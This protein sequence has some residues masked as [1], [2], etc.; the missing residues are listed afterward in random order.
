MGTQGAE[1]VGLGALDHHLA[2]HRGDPRRSPGAVRLARTGRLVFPNN[3]GHPISGV[4]L[5]EQPLQPGAGSGGVSCRFHDLRH[6]SVAL[7]IAAGPIQ[8]DPDRMGHSSIN[9]T[10][11]RYGHLFPELDEAIATSFETEIAALGLPAR[12]KSF[13]AH[14]RARAWHWSSFPPP[15]PTESAVYQVYSSTG[16]PV[17][18]FVTRHE[19]QK[20]RSRR[21][22]GERA[23]GAK[24][25]PISRHGGRRSY[26]SALPPRP[27]NYV[28]G[29]RG[30]TSRCQRVAR[31]P[32]KSAARRDRTPLPFV[33]RPEGVPGEIQKTARGVSIPAADETGRSR[34]FTASW[35]RSGPISGPGD[36]SRSH[37]CYRHFCHSYNHHRSHGSLGWATPA[38]TLPVL[39]GTTS[40]CTIQ[41]TVAIV[42]YISRTVILAAL[43]WPYGGA[44]RSMIPADDVVGSR[45]L[46]VWW[47]KRV[48]TE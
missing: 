29:S 28:R 32:A 31:P 25:R 33:E 26:V 36:Q 44:R 41:A 19:P 18:M 48:R 3:A 7:A 30:A 42:S 5:L 6:I 46:C 47:T 39:P 1:D 34:G 4:E 24:P 23:I 38:A 17:I 20:S 12:G 13:R 9:V 35:W 10:L 21:A 15:P 8:G 40:T 45:S 43:A 37:H 22:R 14:L 16:M 27:V 11:D 2:V